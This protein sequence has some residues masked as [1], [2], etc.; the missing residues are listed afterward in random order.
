MRRTNLAASLRLSLL[1][2]E[3][4]EEEKATKRDLLLVF[5]RGLCVSSSL[6]VVVR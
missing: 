2:C 3:E 4:G 1:P 6:V 5:L